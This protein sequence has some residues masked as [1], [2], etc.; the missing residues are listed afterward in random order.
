MERFAVVVGCLVIL[1]TGTDGAIITFDGLMAGAASYGFD[2][3][4]DTLDDVVFALADASAFVTAGFGSSQTYIDEPGPGGTSRLSPDLRVDFPSGARGMLN[5]GFA[6][7]SS[8][9]GGAASLLIY[10]VSDTLLASTTVPGQYT[11]PSG[12]SIYPEGFVHLP[13][14][15]MASYATMD[16]TTDGDTFIIDNFEGMYGMDQTKGIPAPGALVLGSLGI[17]LIGWYRWRHAF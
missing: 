14:A 8:M 4:G 7:N 9:E 6:P 13:F 3:D 12:R 15:G 11:A 1:A 16:F 2:S 10:D 17:A 5:F